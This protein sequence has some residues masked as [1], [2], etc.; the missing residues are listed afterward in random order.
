MEDVL[1]MAEDYEKEIEG[2]YESSDIPSSPDFETV[3]NF[4]IRVHLFDL[5]S[6]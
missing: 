1:R 3:Q 6:E 2:L 4:V 5:Y